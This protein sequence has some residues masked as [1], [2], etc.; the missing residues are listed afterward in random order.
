MKTFQEYLALAGKDGLPRS[1]IILGVRMA[2][3]GLRELGLEDSQ[4]IHDDLIVVVETDRCLPD[5][6]ELVTGCRLGNRKLKLRDM[7]KMAAT[8]LEVP[9]A[10]AVRV[11]A[12]EAANQRALEMFPDL[13]KEAALGKAYCILSDDELFARKWV[14]VAIAPE[15][16]PNFRTSR[17]PCALCGESIAFGKQ[18]LQGER[19]LCRSCAGDSYFAAL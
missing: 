9:N 12:R 7:G 13:D 17:V 10:R 18:I 2:L 3:L 16:I 11:A 8:L 14:H 5:A 1:G 15:D 6:M 19:T 4:Q